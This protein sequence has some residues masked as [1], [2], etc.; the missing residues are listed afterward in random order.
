MVKKALIV[1][2]AVAFCL[3]SVLMMTSCAK[4]GVK[5]EEPSKAPAPEVKKPEAAPAKPAAGPTAA[6]DE[7]ARKLQME[8]RVFES[9]NI[10]FDFDKSEI[11]PEARAIL[12][13]KAEWMRG[14]PQFSVRIEGHCDERGTNEY[15]LALGERRANAAKKFLEAMGISSSRVDTM[16]YGEERPADPGHN[17][18]A[19]AK[20]RRDEFRLLQK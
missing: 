1:L 6:D 18:A 19:W 15:N 11:K 3:G 9:E 2:V 14:N 13:K 12:E 7:A 4:K 5:M 8:V 17:E 20:N 16:S 10:Y